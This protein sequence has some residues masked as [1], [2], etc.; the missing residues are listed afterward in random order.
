MIKMFKGFLAI[1][2]TF[3]VCMVLI[4]VGA[5]LGASG[6]GEMGGLKKLNKDS[7]LYMNLDGVIYDVE[8][9][10]TDLRKY[11]KKDNIKA[12]LIRIN[13]PGGVVS[14]SQEIY[15][16]IIKVRDEFKKPVVVFGDALVASG[17]YYAAIGASQIVVNSG[18][19]MG[20]IG[21]IMQ[22]NNLEKLYSWAKTDPFVIKSGKYKDS[23]ASFRKMRDDEKEL[24]QSMIDEVYLQFRNTVIKER[25]LSQDIMNKYADG[26]IFTGE[27]AVK[28]GFADKLGGYNMALKTAAQLAGLDIDDP[29]IFTPPPKKEELLQTLINSKVNI[30]PLSNAIEMIKPHL[31]GK[32][33]FLMPGT[34]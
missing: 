24:F 5:G 18:T 10:L 11:S 30:G 29:S 4:S 25:N 32:P 7:I 21:V 12:V 15:Q 23:G 3:I 28:V 13:S 2:A 16:E 9:F 20:S 17:G 22:F 14:P 8:T 31:F 33:L 27:T 26:R 1:I 34:F 19:M 6:L